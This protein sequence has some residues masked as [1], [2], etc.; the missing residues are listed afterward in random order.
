MKK[1][2]FVLA[3]VMVTSVFVAAQ[4]LPQAATPSHYQITFT[5]NFADNTFKGEETIDVQVMKPTKAITL[6][7]QEID[8]HHVTITSGKQSQK[9]TVSENAQDEMATFTTE[10]PVSGAAQIKINFTGKLNSHLAGLYLS[11]T[12]K[13]KYAVSQMEGTE[14]GGGG[15]PSPRRRATTAR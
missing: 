11:Q 4:K 13:R 9:A 12:K 7:A 8:F 10:Q 14:W 6:N 5:P 3:L 15:P 2:C 1:I